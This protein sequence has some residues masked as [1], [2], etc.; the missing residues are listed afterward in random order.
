M[1]NQQGNLGSSMP[2]IRPFIYLD[3]YPFVICKSCSIG[4]IASEVMNHLKSKH[5]QIDRKDRKRINAAIMTMDGV[6]KDQAE[7]RCWALPPPTTGPIVYIKPPKNDGLGCQH[8]PYVVRDTVQIRKHYREQHGLTNGPK[9][10]GSTRRGTRREQDPVPWRVGVQCQRICHWGYGNRWFEVGRVDEGG[11]EDHHDSQGH[12]ENPAADI[13]R[14]YHEDTQAFTTEAREDIQGIHDKWEANSWIM[15]CGWAHHLEGINP[16]HMLEVMQPIRPDEP[17]LQ[18]MWEVFERVLDSA[19]AA[20]S[21]CHPGTAELFEVQR[22]EGSITTNDPFQGLMEPDAWQ[23]YKAWWMTLM[24]IWRRL[25]GPGWSVAGD[26]E[27]GDEEQQQQQQQQQRGPFSDGESDGGSSNHSRRSSE[28]PSV[29]RKRPPYRMTIR[30]EELWKEFSRAVTYATRHGVQPTG[31]YSDAQLQRGCLD[32]V[33]QFLDHPFKTGNHYENIIISALA[34]MG[35][36]REG[37][38][39]VPVG[40][41]TPIYSAVIKVARYLVLYQSMLEREAQVTQLRQYMTARQAREE[42][43]GLFRIVRHKMLQFMIR[44]PEGVAADP[45]PMNW[46]LNTRAYGMHIHFTTPGR[47]TIDWRGDQIIHGSIKFRMYEISDMLHNLLLH[48][49]QTLAQLVVGKVGCQRK[50]Q[51]R[52]RT[53]ELR[54]V[55]AGEGGEHEVM[56]GGGE[57]DVM[58]EE[59]GEG[60]PRSLPRI[61][62]S[63]IEDRHGETMLDH[64]FLS[65]EDNADWVRRGEGW[66]KDQIKGSPAAREAWT[67][68]SEA[69]QSVYREAAVREYGRLLQP[70]KGSVHHGGP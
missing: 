8:C 34:V 25:E 40:K 11:H 60:L 69:G 17:V 32:L 42:A 50:M 41:Y 63:R 47:E 52:A 64:S 48:T 54:Q 18:K 59:E 1:T 49:R 70:I 19:Y 23:R 62:W 24:I 37:R 65:N 39:W 38:G 51:G 55:T 44:T 3:E 20:A 9:R 2:S 61:P 16:D 12:D 10:T 22:K 53:R 21:R 5:S 43:E 66:V 31:Q 35:I 68:M 29:E 33:V 30:Q 13:D 27:E 36:D 57:Y 67:T 4:I 58:A 26:E 15:R 56:G 7:L 46:I 45:T 6:A 28:T 14:M